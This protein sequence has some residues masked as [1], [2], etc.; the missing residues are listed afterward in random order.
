MGSSAKSVGRFGGHR[1]A[2]NQEG[3]PRESEQQSLDVFLSVFE[4][5]RLRRPSIRRCHSLRPG[6]S[7]DG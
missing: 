3:A 5:V 2:C 7:P 6:V 4:L 1:V